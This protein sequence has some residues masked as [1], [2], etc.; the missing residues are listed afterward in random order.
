MRTK[1]M[2]TFA[3]YEIHS[4]MSAVITSATHQN[5]QFQSRLPTE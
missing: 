3:L 1:E 2:Y 5:R 4:S